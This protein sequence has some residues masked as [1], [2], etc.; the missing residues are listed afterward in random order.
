MSWVLRPRVYSNVHALL[1]RYVYLLGSCSRVITHDYS[2]L[3]M[4]YS[5]VPFEVRDLKRYIMMYQAWTYF[6]GPLSTDIH[7]D[8]L[9]ES[10]DFQ[11]FV[12]PIVCWHV[13]YRMYICPEV[14]GVSWC[15]YGDSL[16]IIV[17][18]LHRRLVPPAFLQSWSRL[19]R[20]S[21]SIFCLAM[22]VLDTFPFLLPT[23]QAF[24]IKLLDH[25]RLSVHCKLSIYYPFGGKPHLWK[26][27]IPTLPRLVLW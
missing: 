10:L 23:F 3:R 25:I 18:W 22:S 7:E 2:R 4:L 8:I 11:G 15:I 20:P 16:S 24:Q 17:G 9:F 19:L 12:R 13:A 14:L 21:M 26:P 27:H 5:N 6:F 1:S